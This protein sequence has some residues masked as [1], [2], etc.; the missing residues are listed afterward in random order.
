[1]VEKHSRKYS[2][3]GV[4]CDGVEQHTVMGAGRP[5]KAGHKQ[6]TPARHHIKA[7]EQRSHV[8]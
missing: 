4:T 5:E 6:D 7:G 1:M 8:G 3:L 2:H